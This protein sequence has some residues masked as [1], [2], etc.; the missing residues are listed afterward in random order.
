MKKTI[1]ILPIL[2]SVLF[3]QSV[4]IKD[5]ADQLLLQINDEGDGK[6]SVTVPSSA[7]APAPT[8]DKLYNEGG[9]LKWNGNTLGTPGSADG[10]WTVSGSNMSSTVTGNVGIGTINPLSK[11]SV[12]GDGEQWYTIYGETTD[13]WGVYGKT[14]AISGTAVCGYASNDS[15]ENYGGY[16]ENAGISGRG[17]FGSAFNE[18]DGTNYGGYFE[19]Q[20]S[21]GQGVYSIATGS[22]G[23]G[24]YGY[25]SNGSGVNY[26][27]HGKTESSAGWAGYFEGR[28]YFSGNVG[29]GTATPTANLHVGGVDGALFTGTLD[30]G[31]I[32]S[33]GAGTRMMWYPKKA[34]F[35]A[36]DVSSTQWDDGNIGVYSFAMGFSTTASGTVSTAMGNSTTAN[37]GYST[38]MGIGTTASGEASTSMGSASSA[39]GDYSTAMGIGTTASGY[40]STAMGRFNVG[41]GSA[42]SWVSTDPLFEIGIGA[43]GGAEANAVTVLKNGKVG[44]GTITP[45]ELLDVNSNGIRIRNAQT[46]ASSSADGYTGQIVWDVDYMYVCTDGDGPGGGTDTWKRSAMSVW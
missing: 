42:T 23:K 27:V 15:G 11:L 13:G 3:S 10:D 26:G 46:P 33:T 8:T 6:S 44:I 37:G 32:P 18:G 30:S 39:S 36:G 5:T 19:A 40:V 21:S 45:T 17:V 43:N 28:G 7:T 20:G 4:E 16:F 24:V 2:T 29:I 38:A 14:T 12:G 35:R 41:G 25:A 22:S 31:T 34:A 9:T 1:I